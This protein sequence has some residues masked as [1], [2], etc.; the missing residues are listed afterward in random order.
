M[1][2][3]LTHPLSRA[4]HD[5]ALGQFPPAGETT[6]EVGPAPGGPCDAVAFFSDRVV[7]AADLDPDWVR[8]TYHRTVGQVRHDVSGGLGFFCAAI[9]RSLGMPPTL[10]SVLSVAPYRPALLPGRLEVGGE[11][12]AEWMAYH[13]DVRVYQYRAQGVDGT[14]AIGRGPGERWDVT[15]FIAR[16]EGPRGNGARQLLTAAKTL[17]PER[18]PLFGMTPIH[19]MEI[20]RRGLRAE[21]SPICTE[22]LLLTRPDRATL[23]TAEVPAQRP[24]PTD[25]WRRG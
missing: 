4:L 23:G 13:H 1:T 2:T 9:T 8:E 21:F 17:V 22:F 24:D 15:L 3:A 19:R 12:D 11:V 7:V 10:G 14:I 18:G 6:I 5:A 16:S 25:K 20:L